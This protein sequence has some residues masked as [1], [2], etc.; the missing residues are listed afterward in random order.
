MGSV[1]R[2][3]SL[4]SIGNPLSTCLLSCAPI[5]ACEVSLTHAQ[6]T[7]FDFTEETI[8]LPEGFSPVC[9]DLT[10]LDLDGDLDAVVCGRNVDELA[11][12]LEGGPGGSLTPTDELVVPDQMDWAE[13]GDF[14][15]DG[16]VDIVLGTRSWAG[17]VVIFEGLQGGGFT[18]QPRTLRHCRE[19]R[20]TRVGDLDRDS[21]LDL[22]VIGHSSEEILT[23]VGDGTGSFTPGIRLRSSP[24]RNGYPFP[25]SAELIDL[26]SDGFLD[27]AA[28]GLGSRTIDFSFNDGLGGFPQTRSWTVPVLE[29]GTRPGCSYGEWADFDGD[30]RRD[31]LLS[32]TGF[33]PQRFAIARLE[34]SGDISETTLHPGSSSGLSWIPS[35]GDFDG[36]GDTDVVIG[37]ALP[38]TIAFF[39]NVTQPGGELEFLLPQLF[40]GAQFIRYLRAVDLDHDGD[41]DLVA[42]DFTSDRLVIL[43]NNLIG[44]LP[45]EA[46]RNR[47]SHPSS[48]NPVHAIPF[49]GEGERDGASLAKWLSDLSASEVRDLCTSSSGEP[50]DRTKPGG[51]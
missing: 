3:I 47:T 17:L 12:I 36:D 23:L 21:H 33:G 24:W 2:E 28:I 29:D 18:E 20:A 5:L 6:L 40:V 45:R 35:S 51:G 34:Q 15:E 48:V 27:I 16:N 44:G 46:G 9:F 30:G 43:R 8:Q 4:M 38:G 22:V 11:M 49:S 7:D 41:T 1:P 19:I 39:E 32:L 26:D 50:A 13:F 10:D 31:C 25:Q 42:A 14:N 37:H